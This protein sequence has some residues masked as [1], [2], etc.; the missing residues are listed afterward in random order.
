MR[1]T[2][3]TLKKL[4]ELLEETGYT[5]R[6]EKGQFNSGYCLVENRKI[7]VFNKFFDTEARCTS[8]ADIVGKIEIDP[9]HLTEK[10]ADFLQKLKKHA[11]PQ[12]EVSST[13][14]Q[15]QNSILSEGVRSDETQNQ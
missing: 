3:T 10:S 8:L 5:V 4:E 14:P 7:A 9:T 2:Q 6:Y 15:T 13:E 12:H 1:Y 11:A